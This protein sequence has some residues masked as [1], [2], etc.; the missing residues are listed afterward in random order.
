MPKETAEEASPDS[1]EAAAP[2]GA[3][4]VG[5]DPSAGDSEGLTNG[6]KRRRKRKH[7]RESKRRPAWL[8]P[9]VVV[10]IGL[11][12]FLWWLLR[13]MNEVPPGRIIQTGF[14]Q[15]RPGATRT[16]AVACASA[17]S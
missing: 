5:E 6:H 1:G 8:W 13:R 15:A 3:P 9:L 2:E 14:L 12:I 17:S 11:M 7:R 4:A 10:L 16:P